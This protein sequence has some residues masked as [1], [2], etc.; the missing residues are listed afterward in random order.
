MLRDGS[1]RSSIAGRKAIIAYDDRGNVREREEGDGQISR[2][3]YNEQQRLTR[4]ANETVACESDFDDA[5]HAIQQVFRFPE[6]SVYSLALDEGW[7]VFDDIQLRF[8]HK[9]GADGRVFAT[10]CSAWEQPVFYRAGT[11]QMTVRYPNGITEIIAFHPSGRRRSQRIRNQRGEIINQRRYHYDPAGRLIGIDDEFRGKA[12]YVYD[13]KQRLTEV[14]WSGQKERTERYGYDQFENLARD[15]EPWQFDRTN[16]LTSRPGSVYQYD[17]CGCRNE[18]RAA[19][20]GRTGYRFDARGRL[21][22]AV[23]P[24]GREAEYRYD[25]TGRRVIKRFAT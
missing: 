16:R 15:G 11:E 2:W 25:A 8:A 12:R 14:S 13:G 7:L 3:E 19:G 1:Y 4:S 22:A 10:V 20:R 6:G 23:L 9:G 5:S 21:V 17:R 24:D 18:E